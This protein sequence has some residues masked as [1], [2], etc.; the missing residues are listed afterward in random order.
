[1]KSAPGT[2]CIAN[3]CPTASIPICTH[4]HTGDRD[5]SAGLSALAVFEDFITG[6]DPRARLR[7]CTIICD[8][9]GGKEAGQRSIDA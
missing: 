5:R 6:R 4:I 2:A 1:V 7:M 8:R 9:R 3:V